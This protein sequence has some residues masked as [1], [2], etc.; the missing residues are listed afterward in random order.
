MKKY[1]IATNYNLAQRE[2]YS[3]VIEIDEENMT[4]IPDQDTLSVLHDPKWHELSDDEF[5][6]EYQT[7][8]AKL[9]TKH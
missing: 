8:S 1:G 4:A 9:K 7:F 2:L 5:L 6:L 3:I